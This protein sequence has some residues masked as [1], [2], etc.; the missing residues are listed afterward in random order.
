MTLSWYDLGLRMKQA[1]FGAVSYAVCL[2]F[3]T[4]PFNR[5]IVYNKTGLHCYGDDFGISECLCDDEWCLINFN[6]QGK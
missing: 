6:L 5:R 3:N 4:L 2:S 1:R